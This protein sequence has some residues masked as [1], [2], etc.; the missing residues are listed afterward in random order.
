MRQF[1]VEKENIKNGLI[2]LIGKD[3]RYLRQVLRVKKGDMLNVR[4]DD[5]E[6]RSTTVAFIDDNAKKIILQVCD[7]A[8]GDASSRA[9]TSI[10]RGTQAGEIKNAFSDRD[11]VLF[12]FIPKAQKFEL[13]VRQA[14]ECGI[15]VIV[16][17]IGDFSEKNC[18]SMFSGAKRERFDRII[19][20]ARQQSG[21]PVATKI[22]E[23]MTL[24]DAVDW[25]KKVFGGGEASSLALALWERT[26]GEVPLF[27]LVSSKDK[28]TKVAI[29]VGN[30]GGISPAEIKLLNE[31]GF[32]STIHFEGNILRCE[33]AAL[34]GI[35]AV[36]SAIFQ[37]NQEKQ[38]GENG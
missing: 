7:A 8:E 22:V 32:F 17:V 21:S 20:E 18:T 37:L 38:G 26:E 4:L 16:P 6:L 10:T 25:W 13:I 35:A 31:K 5:G 11:F 2:E 19:K 15:S 9:G 30:E 1:I 27:K 3:F 12:Q 33:T 36:Q 29:A 14:T 23:P 34:Y 28:I 24:T